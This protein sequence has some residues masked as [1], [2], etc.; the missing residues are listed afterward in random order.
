MVS[1]RYKSRFQTKSIIEWNL[2]KKKKLSS[3]TFLFTNDL[4]VDLCSWQRVH[5]Y[6]DRR[7]KHLCWGRRQPPLLVLM[8]DIHL[9]PLSLRGGQ[10]LPPPN[11]STADGNLQGRECV[12]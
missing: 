10:L 5:R 2:T 3:H 1:K 4:F 11:P 6:S 7:L 9:P 8:P 12:C